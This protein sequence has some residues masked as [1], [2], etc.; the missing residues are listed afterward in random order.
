M[1]TSLTAL[2]TTVKG[3][4]SVT[5]SEAQTKDFPIEESSQPFD[6]SVTQDPVMEGTLEIY[7]VSP[8]TA[9]KLFGGTATTTGT[10]ATQKVVYTP[11]T[12]YVPLEVSG[13]LES[14]AGAILAMVR[15]QLLPVW[16]LFFQNEELGKITLKFKVM[17]P[18]KAATAPWTLTFPDPA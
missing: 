9:V 12:T 17:A 14:L 2:G 1:G 15:I 8:A 13:E 3:S 18:T 4:V 7:D 16:N 10:G 11:P 5:T 6:S